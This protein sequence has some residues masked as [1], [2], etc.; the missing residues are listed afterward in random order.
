[1]PSATA[2]FASA[3]AGTGYSF[4]NTLLKVAGEQFLQDPETL[5]TEAFGNESLFIVVDDDQAS[6]SGRL[7]TQRMPKQRPPRFYEQDDDHLESDEDDINGIID[8]DDLF[9]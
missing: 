8:E 1:M 7:K 6:E 4:S 9:V 2:S 5:Q 3:A